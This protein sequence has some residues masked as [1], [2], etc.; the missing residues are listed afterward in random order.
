MI[1]SIQLLPVTLFSF[2]LLISCGG[3]DQKAGGAP[4]GGAAAN[5]VKDYPV[6]TVSTRSATLFNDFPATIQGQQ[7]IEISP[8]IDGYIER[9]YVDEGATVRKG[10][11]LFNI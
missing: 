11:P 3:K 5:P 8:K 7:N 10:Q 9:I 6:I 1:K 2:L 4:G